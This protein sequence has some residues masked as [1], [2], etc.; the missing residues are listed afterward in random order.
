MKE[1]VISAIVALL[2]VIP[3]IIL[4]DMYFRVF[5]ILIGLYGLKELLDLKKGIPSYIKL[6]SY[7]F[8]IVM[9][10]FG[11]VY[12]G[13]IIIMDFSLFLL[14]F[15]SL[16]I[17]LLI[18]KKPYNIED[19][20]Y[21]CSSILFLSV[22]F[23]LIIIIRE[24]S[25]YLFIYLI[26]ISTVTDTFAYLIGK[27]YGKNKLMEDVSPNKTIEG[28]IAGLVVGTIAGSI[29]YYFLIGHSNIFVIIAMTAL[30]STIGQIGDLVFSSIKRH[31]KIKDFSNIMPG[32][33]GILDRLDSIIFIVLS[34]VI[35]S[36][37]L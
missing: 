26:L 16:S 36:V 8:F 7:L 15:I 24:L 30:L 37:L 3:L 5:A 10:L 35:I 12:N 32:H 13:D 9:L 34:Y 28:S 20:F 22:S 1:R 6:S 31:F 18:F 4:G 29:F 2:I 33:G 14:I 11:Y 25:L 23:Y 27:K 17:S 21:L 19:V